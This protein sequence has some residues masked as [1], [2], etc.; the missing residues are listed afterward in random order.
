M[1]SGSIA[2]RS[3][4]IA[5]SCVQF[6]AGCQTTE[7]IVIMPVGFLGVKSSTIACLASTGLVIDSAVTPTA[8][9]VVPLAVTPTPVTIKMPFIETPAGVMDGAN[10][11]FHVSRA[12]SSDGP[13]KV[14]RNGILLEPCPPSAPVDCAGEYQT[15]GS[16]ILFMPHYEPNPGDTLQVVYWHAVP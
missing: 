6:A 15:G 16:V 8:L 10:R 12:P 11:M 1:R 9:K 7:A 3:C 13:I 2:I 14:Y 4:L 5:I